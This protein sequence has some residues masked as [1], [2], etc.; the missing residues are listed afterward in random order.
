MEPP[1]SSQPRALPNLADVSV[2]KPLPAITNDKPVVANS[3]FALPRLD[4]FLRPSTALWCTGK[5]QH[6]FAVHASPDLCP[7]RWCCGSEQARPREASK[8]QGQDAKGS[9]CYEYSAAHSSRVRSHRF[10]NFHQGRR[11]VGGPFVGTTNE[12]VPVVFV[13]PPGGIVGSLMASAVE[14]LGGALI[15]TVS[16]FG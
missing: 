15:L 1:V 4:D 8:G 12:T 5:G 9:R 2:L 13:A 3:T 16:F 11:F 10:Q 6:C 7:S 14:G